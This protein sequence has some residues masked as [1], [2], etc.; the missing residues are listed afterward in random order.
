[1]SA[2][3]D[4]LSSVQAARQQQQQRYSGTGAAEEVLHEARWRRL[5]KLVNLKLKL[6][7]N[8]NSKLEA[9]AFKFNFKPE[10]KALGHR[11]VSL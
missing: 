4:I 1:V 5:C 11:R 9:T 7:L 6:N 10:L 8:L 2:A 3:R